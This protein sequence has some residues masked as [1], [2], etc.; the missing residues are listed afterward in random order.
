M[1]RKAKNLK[2]KTMDFPF[3]PSQENSGMASLVLL[4]AFCVLLFYTSICI[5]SEN[6]WRLEDDQN[7][8]V[9]ATDNT[10]KND[11]L[12]KITEIQ[13]LIDKASREPHGRTSR[14]KTAK[15]DF[16]KLK[17]NFPD[18]VGADLDLFINAEMLL[19]K[20]KFSKA[21]K[22]YDKLIKNYTDSI[23]SDLA[24][25]R[26]F[27]IGKAYLDGQKQVVL[28]IFKISGNSEGI[29]ILEKV[30]DYAGY[31]SKMGIEASVAIAKNYEKNK[32]FNEAY[33]KWWE[34][35]SLGKKDIIDRDA[36]LGMAKAKYDIYNNNPEAKKPFY[37]SSCL[38]SAKSYYLMLK[39][40][41]PEYAK[42]INVD[43]T[44]NVITEQLAYKELS[45][46]LYYQDKGYQQSA[47]LYFDMVISN[48]PESKSA[49]IARN[50]L[51]KAGS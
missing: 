34:I 28:G 18:F 10:Q 6:T 7:W 33:L 21:A 43:E 11:F 39:S 15:N 30:T 48:W 40:Y 20:H 16:D 29:R 32:K 19:A 3:L 4:F 42:Q 38:K 24:I 22:N 9:V 13:D 46:G 41:Y 8:D 31:D 27:D 45:T 36:L 12:K 2:L 5:S 14:V 1:M 47:N 44:L 49:E 51:G 26:L 50:M 17:E 35:Y 23:L 25:K 37:D